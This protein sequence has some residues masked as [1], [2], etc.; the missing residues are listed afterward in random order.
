MLKPPPLIEK[1]SEGSP[2]IAVP[3]DWKKI[4]KKLAKKAKKKNGHPHEGLDY[5]ETGD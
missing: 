2:S 4:K 1:M 3:V 5:E